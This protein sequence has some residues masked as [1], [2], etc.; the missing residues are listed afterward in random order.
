MC[1]REKKNSK[2][3]VLDI[4]IFPKIKQFGSYKEV[5]DHILAMDDKL[6]T[7]TFLVNLITYCPNR[8]D[9]LGVMKSF[10]N[11]PEKDCQK[12]DPPEYFTIEVNIL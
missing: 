7:E 10:L 9:D 12:L 1:M 8:E 5:R 2:G 6:C 3:H 4:V 11:G